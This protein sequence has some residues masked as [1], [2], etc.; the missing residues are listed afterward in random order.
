MNINIFMILK[1][2]ENSL[3]IKRY[4]F[5]KQVVGIILFF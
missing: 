1:H 3:N 2:G 5:Y 4:L